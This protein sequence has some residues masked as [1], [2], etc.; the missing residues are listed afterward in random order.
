MDEKI[1]EN[2][3]NAAALGASPDGQAASLDKISGMIARVA[4]SP[5]AT[6]TARPEGPVMLADAPAGT[7][8]LRSDE[9][10]AD[11]GRVLLESAARYA[12]PYIAVPRVVN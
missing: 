8:R 7:D 5:E 12:E 4:A 3:E 2:L 6:E 11:N 1:R 9:P 10:S